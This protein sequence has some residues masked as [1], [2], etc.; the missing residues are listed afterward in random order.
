IAE[1]LG[2]DRGPVAKRR[3][4]AH[5]MDAAEEAAHPFERCRVGELGGAA[6]AL[7]S[8]GKAEAR[9][10]VQRDA[11]GFDRRHHRNLAGRELGD[12][13]V[14]FANLQVGPAA[15]PIELYDDGRCVIT[16]N[17]VD[18]I[19]IAAE[20]EKTSIAP[21]PDGVERVEHDSRRELGIR[22]RRRG[23]YHPSIVRGWLSFLRLRSIADG[24]SQLRGNEAGVHREAA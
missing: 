23:R 17:L 13:L 22:M 12:E 16:P 14:L 15:R 19:F 5:G 18:A 9:K 8:T 11:A 1:R 24:A 21:E 3:L 7:W 6:A 10:W 4:R 2:I 20:G